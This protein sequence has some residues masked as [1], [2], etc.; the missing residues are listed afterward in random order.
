M[1]ESFSITQ[2]ECDQLQHEYLVN[3]CLY[4]LMKARE[5]VGGSK[6]IDEAIE[7]LSKQT[8]FLTEVMEVYKKNNGMSASDYLNQ[9]NK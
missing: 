1:N 9:K 7:S 8:R 5:F 6:T 3:D 4:Y 2:E